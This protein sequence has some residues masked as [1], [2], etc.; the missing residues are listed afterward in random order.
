[1]SAKFKKVSGFFSD[2][3]ECEVEFKNGVRG[4]GTGTTKGAARKAAVADGKS[5]GG[6]GAMTVLA[7]LLLAAGGS[8]GM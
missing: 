5:S 4:R 6:T 8:L 3:W 7:L 2:S 1:M